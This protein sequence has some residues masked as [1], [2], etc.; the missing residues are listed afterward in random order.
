MPNT[1]RELKINLNVNHLCQIPMNNPIDDPSKN[2]NKI[3]F[4]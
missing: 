1:L 3:I 2:M 4:Y